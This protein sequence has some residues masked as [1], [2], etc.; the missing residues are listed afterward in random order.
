MTDIDQTREAHDALINAVANNTASAEDRAQAERIAANDEDFARELSFARSLRKAVKAQTVDVPSEFALQR[1]R[2]EIKREQPAAIGGTAGRWAEFAP[3]V[4][5]AACL[6]VILQTGYIMTRD[7]SQHYVT[8]AANSEADVQIRFSN[9]AT[10]GQ[11]QRFLREQ[12][13]QILAGPSAAGI[14]RLGDGV[15]GPVEGSR[16]E[17]WQSEYSFIDFAAVD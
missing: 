8:A 13:M 9:D 11:I 17:Q 3:K 5:I 4:A 16:I 7:A 14:Y 6:V 10:A 15:D 1:L 12:K 2:R